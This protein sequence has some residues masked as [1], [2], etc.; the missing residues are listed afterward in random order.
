MSLHRIAQLTFS[1]TESRDAAI[2][3]AWPQ[4]TCSD[5]PGEY[6]LPGGHVLVV[7]H[8]TVC[9]YAPAPAF[10]EGEVINLVR[11]RLASEQPRKEQP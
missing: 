4:R 1:T 5:V 3:A 7:Q 10:T 2:D 8:L 9:V 6:D 11:D